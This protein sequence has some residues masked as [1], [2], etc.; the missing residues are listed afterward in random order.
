MPFRSNLFGDTIIQPNTDWDEIA[1]QCDELGVLGAA[2]SVAI[3]NTT[4]DPNFK[5]GGELV[6]YGQNAE[7]EDGIDD[8][9]EIT[10]QFDNFGSVESARVWLA[11]IGVTTIEETS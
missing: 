1:Y 6:C 2:P 4:F 9:I 10:F 8:P 11:D 5:I 3:L 7:T